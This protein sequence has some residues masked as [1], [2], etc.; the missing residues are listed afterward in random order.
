MIKN[1]YNGLFYAD[2]DEIID[3]AYNA[4]IDEDCENES[5]NIVEISDKP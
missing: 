1:D 3:F 5:R 2:I 4:N